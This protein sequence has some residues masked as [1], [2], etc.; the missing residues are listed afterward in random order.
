MLLM[1]NESAPGKL[2]SSYCLSAYDFIISASE[3]ACIDAFRRHAGH[4]MVI[5]RMMMCVF[6]AVML[7]CVGIRYTFTYLFYAKIIK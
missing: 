7:L 2:P 5:N 6:V 4:R 3:L 1:Y